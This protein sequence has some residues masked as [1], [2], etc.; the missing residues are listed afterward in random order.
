MSRQARQMRQLLYPLKRERGESIQIHQ[1]DDNDL[2]LTS[3]AITKTYQTHRVKK[4][5]VL[6]V[7]IAR[8]FVYDLAYIA[9]NKNFTS[10]G[11]FDKLFTT[12]IIDLPDLPT[13]IV[14]S[15]DDYCSISG[16]TY[17]VAAADIF[18]GAF[19]ILKLTGLTNFASLEV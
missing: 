16:V 6:P 1:I 7:G 10:G 8:T 17:K 15:L 11:L 12:V 19:Y 14:I 4:A 9:A 2:N 3:G 5:I 13:G 18:E